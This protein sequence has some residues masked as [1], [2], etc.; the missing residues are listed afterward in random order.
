MR[1]SQQAIEVAGGFHETVNKKKRRYLWAAASA[2]ITSMGIPQSYPDMRPGCTAAVY[3]I[4]PQLEWSHTA[5]PELIYKF[6]WTR[7]GRHW[8]L[9]GFDAVRDHAI[10][11]EFPAVLAAIVAGAC[12]APGVDLSPLCRAWSRTAE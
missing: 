2:D 4:S 8:V 3:T 10:I 6:G 11:K 9:F 1:F 7:D 12:T 5:D